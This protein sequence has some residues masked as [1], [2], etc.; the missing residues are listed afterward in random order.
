[1]KNTEIPHGAEPMLVDP[2]KLL[3]A[4][5]I[6]HGSIRKAAKHIGV[7]DVYLS[8]ALRAKRGVGPKLQDFLGVTRHEHATVW[9]TLT[10]KSEPNARRTLD[11]PKKR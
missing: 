9:Y 4:I 5:V 8:D 2:I 7:S 6:Y 3:N 1:M 11:S 10:Q